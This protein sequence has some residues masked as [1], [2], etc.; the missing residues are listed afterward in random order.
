VLLSRTG[1][2]SVDEDVVSAVYQAFQDDA[3]TQLT[4]IV[5]VRSAEIVTYAVNLTLRLPIGPDPALVKAKARTAV[6]AYTASR[7]KVGARVYAQM[8]E[9]V[10][11]VG[12]VE[13]VV[14]DLVDIVPEADQA[15]YC[16]S[17]VVNHELVT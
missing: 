11:S 9:A 14:S 3:A 2:G 13:E 6:L 12:P 17:V 10:A 1:D 5:S 8:I 15:A 4:D 16:T 7:H